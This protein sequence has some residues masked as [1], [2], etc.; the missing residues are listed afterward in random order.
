MIATTA[1]NVSIMT[2]TLLEFD[3]EL[4]FS[5]SGDVA[6]EVFRDRTIAVSQRGKKYVAALVFDADHEVLL[7]KIASGAVRS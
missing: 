3:F 7:I 5:R 4:L 1:I 6:G 2:M